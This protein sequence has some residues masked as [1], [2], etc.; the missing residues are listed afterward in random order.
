MEIGVSLKDQFFDRPAIIDAIGVTRAKAL[1]RI[2]AYVQKVAQRSMR[3][4]KKPTPKGKPPAFHGS[5][6]ITLRSIQFGW[7][8]KQQSLIIGPI[9]SNSSKGKVSVPRLHEFGGRA[10]IDEW[11]L[12]PQGQETLKKLKRS[13]KLSSQFNVWM[14]GGNKL[15]GQRNGS[16]KIS[17][18]PKDLMYRIDRRVRLAKYPKRPTMRPALL[19][20]RAKM[21]HMFKGLLKQTKTP[22]KR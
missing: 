12:I 5:T 2:G 17:S 15:M 3:P 13:K 19:K 16:G 9:K 8:A 21:P 4:Q 6:T 22:R 7:G 18:L 20:S 11:K 14:H 1:G 10:P